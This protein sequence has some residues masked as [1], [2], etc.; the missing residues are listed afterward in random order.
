MQ[1]W[2][3]EQPILILL[4]DIHWMDEA[5]LSLALDLSR[6]IAHV[7]VV[8][9]FVHRPAQRVDIFQTA[10]FIQLPHIHIP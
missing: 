9:L 5:S 2:A 3:Q 4:D 1:S 6:S 10:D 8:L 7:P